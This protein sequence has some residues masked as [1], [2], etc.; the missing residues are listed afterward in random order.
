[1][2][3]T[4]WLESGPVCC[5]MQLLAL[6]VARVDGGPSCCG[7]RLLWLGCQSVCCVCCLLDPLALVFKIIVLLLG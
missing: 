7:A 2:D 3:L 4:G 1:M 6:A 5:R